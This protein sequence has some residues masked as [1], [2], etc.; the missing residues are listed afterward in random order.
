VIRIEKPSSS[1]DA[2]GRSSGW[3]TFV[4]NVP[5]NVEDASGQE[6]YQAQ[7]F[8]DSVTHVVRMPYIAGVASKMRAV[9]ADPIL[10]ADRYMEIQYVLQP[11]KKRIEHRLYCLESVTNA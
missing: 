6:A 2:L 1:Q 10:N 11:D 3:E 4:D 5:A 7:R 9:W 8:A